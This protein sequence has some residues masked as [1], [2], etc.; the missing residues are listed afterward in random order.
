[1]KRRVLFLCTGNSVRSQMAAGL[2][3][4]D[5][6]GAIAAFSAGTHPVGV[7]PFAIEVMAEAGIDIS[8]ESS[9]HLSRYE[10]EQFD[11]V[12][13]L[14]DDAHER[15]PV[16][17]GGV[18]HRHLGFP[19]PARSAGSREQQLEHFHRVRDDIRARLRELFTAE[20]GLE[21]KD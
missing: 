18:K 9:D 15:C 14:C 2:A 16:F 7:N 21:A 8:S 13:T 5:F 17:F 11:Y 1:M 10:G 6:A 3:N 12:I 20:L 4:H 19:D